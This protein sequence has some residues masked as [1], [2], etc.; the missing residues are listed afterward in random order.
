LACECAAGRDRGEER[1]K[2]ITNERKR[3]GEEVKREIPN[4]KRREA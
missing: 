1:R 2:G 4:E 3:E